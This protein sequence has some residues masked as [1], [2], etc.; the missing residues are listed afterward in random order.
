MPNRIETED[1]FCKFCGETFNRGRLISGRLG[2]IE[3]YKKRKFCFH[4]CYTRWHFGENHSYW[5]GGFKQ[6]PDGY[7]RDGRTDK[8]IHRKVIENSIGRNLYKSE[9]VHHL[10][11]DPSDNRLENLSI[12]M[13]TDH[14]KLHNALRKRDAQGRWCR[15]EKGA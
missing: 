1:K 10:N 2:A 4:R 15:R 5:K 8:Y 3:D 13:N 12:M 14:G 11:G 6:R 9:V 7:I